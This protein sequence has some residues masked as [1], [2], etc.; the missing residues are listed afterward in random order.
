MN[1]S[2]ANSARNR[3]TS[4]R[5]DRFRIS[6]PDT[7][8]AR[9][10]QIAE[11][12]PINAA[13]TMNAA[14]SATGSSKSP[15]KPHFT[16]GIGKS[17]AGDVGDTAGIVYGPVSDLC[18]LFGASHWISSVACLHN[19]A[20]TDFRSADC[21]SA[22]WLLIPVVSVPA[23][24]ASANVFDIYTII[25]LAL[26]VFI[27]LRLRSVL[28][29]RTGRERP[30]YDPYSARDAV[31]GTNDNVVA[32]PGRGGE[33]PPARLRR[34]TRRALEGDRRAGIGRLTQPRRHCQSRPRFRPEAFRRRRT[35]GL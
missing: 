8:V 35:A 22:D 16:N 30:P 15:I 12:Q 11:S 24:E 7:V 31:R 1:P 29:Q 4:L 32:L 34:S 6:E 9:K 14:I 28:G 13:I 2:L 21:W 5:P 25:F 17:R 23:A 27:F 20:G 10:R 33:A 3:S 19:S 18:R 26:A